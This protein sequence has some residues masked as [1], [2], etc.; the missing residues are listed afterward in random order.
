VI[1]PA[2]LAPRLHLHVAEALGVHE[3][4]M[5]VERGQH[6]VDRRLDQLGVVRHLDVI[7]ADALEDVAEQ[8][9]LAVGI[10]HGRDRLAHGHEPRL[11]VEGDGGD[12]AERRSEHQVTRLPDHPRTFS[13]FLPAHQGEGS[14]AV[15]SLRN[16]T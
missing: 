7:G 11:A 2:E 4:R 6:A 16:S 12:G 14:M 13:S 5:G 9:E 8:I 1:E 10:R 15:P 3:A